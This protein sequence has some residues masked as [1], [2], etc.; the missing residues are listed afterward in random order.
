MICEIAWAS[1]FRAG[2]YATSSPDRPNGRDG[3]RHRDFGTR[4]GTIDLAVPKL[5]EGSYFPEWLLE[6]RKRAERAPTS[7]VATCYWRG[8]ECLN[9][10]LS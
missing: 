7:V 9:R 5:R 10:W 1:C 3:Y 4:A 8:F 6:R 2:P